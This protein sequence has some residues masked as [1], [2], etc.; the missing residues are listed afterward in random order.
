MKKW[1]TNIL[2]VFIL[3][4]SFKV[5]GQS[6]VIIN[7]S[8]YNTWQLSN[9]ACY[10]CGSFYVMVV[11]SANPDKSGLYYYDIYLWSNSFYTT[12]YASSSYVK[13][14]KIYGI[15]PSGKETLILKLDYA[16]VPPKSQYFDG[17][18]YLAYVYSGSARQTIKLTWSEIS[19][20]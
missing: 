3:T 10:G 8:E 18:F 9:D 1:I 20:W 2:L 19:I 11:N 12:G 13:N 15:D 7:N 6:N 5:K 17:N 16:L 14:I 4:L